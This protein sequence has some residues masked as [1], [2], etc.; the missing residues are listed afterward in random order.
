LFKGGEE[1]DWDEWEDEEYETL[2]DEGVEI[3][4]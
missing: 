4:F 1:L 2:Q 3:T